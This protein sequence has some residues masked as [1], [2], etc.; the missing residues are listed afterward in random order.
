MRS[1]PTDWGCPQAGRWS[2]AVLTDLLTRDSPVP[3]RFDERG[4][5]PAVVGR[6]LIDT[7]DEEVPLPVI[8]VLL[9]GR[10]LVVVVQ[11]GGLGGGRGTMETGTP[12]PLASA[13]I[14]PGR[15]GLTRFR[16]VARV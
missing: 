12:S 7:H 11:P 4:Y 3:Q 15:G 14:V 5:V 16:V 13:S 8:G 9:P 1:W 10:G 6:Q 2:N